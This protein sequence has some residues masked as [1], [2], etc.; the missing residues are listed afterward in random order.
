MARPYQI[1]ALTFTN[2]A[3]GELKSRTSAMVGSE[4]ESVVAGTFHSIFARIMRREG[5]NINIDPRFTIV[6]ADDRR[7]FIKTILKENNIPIGTVR[8]AGIDWA[9]SM[10]KNNL[11]SPDD[12]EELVRDPRDKVVVQVYRH[13]ER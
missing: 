4:G 9:I 5:L 13:Y 2:K 7:R 6:D 10:A 8:P 12:L 1:L 3:A 11:L